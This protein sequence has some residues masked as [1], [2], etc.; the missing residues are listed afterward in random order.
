M[1]N[2]LSLLEILFFF[3]RPL[4]KAATRKVVTIITED[5]LPKEEDQAVKG[6]GRQTKRENRENVFLPSP[7]KR[8][9]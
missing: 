2:I 9:S 8:Q 6:R 4:N 7:G 3:F 5:D 1:E